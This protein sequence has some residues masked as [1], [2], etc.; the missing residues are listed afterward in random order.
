MQA[1]W[2]GLT[3]FFVDRDH[4]VAADLHRRGG[5]RRLRPAQDV[6]V[7]DASRD[8]SSPSAISPSP[9]ARASAQTL[10]GRPRLVRHRARARR[11]AL[12]GESGLG[13]IGHGALGDEAPALS[14]GASSVAVRSCFKGQDLIPMSEDEM[15]EVRGND[16]SIIFQEPM[17]SLNPLHTIEKQIGEILQLHRG[18][19]ARR[20]ARGSSSCS[21]RS[22]S[23]IRRARLGSLSA[24]ALRRAAPARDDRAW[25]S[26]TSRT[27]S[28]PTSRPP[29]STSPC[30]RRSSSC[31]RTCRRGSAW[32]CCSSPTT[33]ASCAR[34]PT[35]SA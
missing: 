6:P 5:A 8:R 17:T 10:R 20:R 7:S 24:P 3:G 25:R 12:V 29:R 23:P 35:A 15:R 21:T 28:S 22:A 1:P 34:S 9:S 33:S 14:A 13:Q 31:S 32:R 16:I 4:A 11:V 18:I 30:R 26:P 19:P 27:C 2:L